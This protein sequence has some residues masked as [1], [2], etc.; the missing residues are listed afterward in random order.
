MAN[1]PI[2]N[3]TA[4]QRL[5][6]VDSI[7]KTIVDTYDVPPSWSR[8]EGFET[9]SRIILEQQVSLMSAKATYEKLSMIITAFIPSELIKLSP[10][11]L[12]IATVSRQKASYI[13]GL[14][15]LI[16]DGNIQLEDL[17]DMNELDAHE[18]LMNVR[19]IGNWTA[20]VYLMFCLQSPDIFPKGD[21]ALN[22]T[23]KEF[24]PGISTEEIYEYV[25]KWSPYCSTASYLLWHYY[26]RKRNR[27]FVI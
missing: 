10:E 3:P 6:E 16:L 2:I 23:I 12:R 27:D 18:A 22:N 4:I 9:L 24:I 5:Q 20:Q 8:P 19:G 26:L 1:V 7:F 25:N 17:S 15:Q 11:E 14:A 13:Q 21:V